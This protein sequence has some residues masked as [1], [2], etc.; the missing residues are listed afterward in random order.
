MHAFRLRGRPDCI[1]VVRLCSQLLVRPQGTAL[2]TRH[3][4]QGT[5]RDR[6]APQETARDLRRLQRTAVVTCQKLRGTTKIENLTKASV[7]FRWASAN[8]LN[9][10]GQV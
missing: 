4:L 8:T 2:M 1:V 3:I 7:Q 5:T 10:A 6:K 9:G